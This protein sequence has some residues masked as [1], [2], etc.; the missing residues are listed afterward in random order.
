M[1]PAPQLRQSP[2]RTLHVRTSSRASLL[3]FSVFALYCIALAVMPSV[4]LAQ[5]GNWNDAITAFW[6]EGFGYLVPAALFIVLVS[7]ARKPVSPIT[8]SM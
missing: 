2:H 6:T 5:R 1:T 8:W 7:V 3:L 4:I